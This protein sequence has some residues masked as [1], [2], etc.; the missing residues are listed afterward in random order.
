MSISNFP[1][2][3][4][5]AAVPTLQSVTTAG[6]TTNKSMR[7]FD[8]GAPTSFSQMDQDTFL[9]NELGSP[10]IKMWGNNSG[11]GPGIDIYDLAGAFRMFLKANIALGSNIVVT[12]PTASGKLAITTDIPGTS[13]LQQVTTAGN[14]TNLQVVSTNSFVAQGGAGI[15]ATVAPV[16]I[17][18]T[19]ATASAAIT[20]GGSTGGALTLLQTGAGFRHIIEGSAVLATASRAHQLQNETGILAHLANC[21]LQPH[22]KQTV[23][24][25]PT[26]NLGAGAGGAGS[27]IA[28]TNCTD[29]SGHVL[30]TTA[31]V[32][33]ALTPFF[34]VVFGTAMVNSP[35]AHLFQNNQAAA[36][37]VAAGQFPFQN[38]STVNTANAIFTTNAVAPTGL[39]QYSFSYWIAP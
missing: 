19:N 9:I 20:S 24:P 10:A 29:I 17:D 36:G 11:V 37:M 35:N 32:P 5:A 23:G 38:Y 39:T 3:P 25:A 27:V 13:T 34:T 1:I 28:I 7:S 26:I 21:F 6:N 12:T 22:P 31:A 15:A 30:I 14:S 4:A 8:P 2:T 33:V 18:V 16:Q